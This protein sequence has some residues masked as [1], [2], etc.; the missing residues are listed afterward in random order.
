[1][2]QVRGLESDDPKKAVIDQRETSELNRAILQLLA[3]MLEGCVFVVLRML[4]TAKKS[5]FVFAVVR[6]P[7]WP[8]REDVNVPRCRG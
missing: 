4:T 3:A 8:Q 6:A 1:M 2:R 5:L 7:V